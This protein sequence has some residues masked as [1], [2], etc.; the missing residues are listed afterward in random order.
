M[1]G[2][3]A[4]D[5]WFA[6]NNTEVLV[7]P[8]RRLETFGATTIDYHLVCELMDS[9]DRVRV[10]EGRLHAYRPEIVTPQRWAESLLEGFSEEAAAKYMEWLQGHESELLMLRYGFKLRKESL[11]EHVVTDRIETVIERVRTELAA[12]KNPLAALVRGVDEPWEVCLVKLA[13]EMVQRSAPHQARELRADPRGER[14]EIEAAF[15]EASRDPART[16]ALA[17]RLRALKRFEEYE[18][19]FFALVRRQRRA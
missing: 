1:P 17:E 2:G 4:F 11:T 8:P 13:V 14:H 16:A 6:V 3:D 7:V 19:R 12:R 15:R 10:R 18:D 5:F 9:V